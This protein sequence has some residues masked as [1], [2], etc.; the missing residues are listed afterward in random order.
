VSILPKIKQ[1]KLKPTERYLLG[2]V[3]K[4]HLPRDK[5]G[6][7]ISSSK[8]EGENKQR[9]F[10]LVKVKGSYG[11]FVV[12]EKLIPDEVRTTLFGIAIIGILIAM[13]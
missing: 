2:E 8:T 7:F 1:E 4:D 5:K 9:S 10:K 6:R 12:K 3:E 13:F 11:S